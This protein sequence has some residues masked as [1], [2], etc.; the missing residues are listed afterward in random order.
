[1]AP[2]DRPRFEV[3]DVVCAHGDDYRRAHHPSAA[4]EAVLKHIAEC[5]TAALGGHLEQCDSCGHQ[6]ISYNSCRDRHCPKCQNTAR[7]EWITER[8]ERLLPTPYFHVVF[9]IPDQ[10]NPLAL[11]NKNAVFN[12]LF[13]AASQTLL[14]IARDEKHLGAQ[15]G[16]TTVLHTWGQNLFF[17]PHL[18][19][20]VTGGGLSSD[21]P[22]WVSARENYLLPVKVLGKLFRG[23]FLAALDNAYENGKLDLTGSTAELSNPGAWRRF[24]AGLYEKDWVVY[25]K[26]PFGGP[27]HVFQY[28]G[29]Y[30]HR[31]AISNH[32]IV[33]LA[34]GKVTF[35]V[36]DYADGCKK[37]L[38]TLD[39]VE[40]L[41]R[42]LLHVLP[43]G[44][45]RIRHYGLCASANV[46]G[47]LVTARRMLEHGT[48]LAPQP[49]TEPQPAIS[50]P[51][52]ERFCEIT[53]ID[54]MACPACTDGRMTRLRSLFGPTTEFA[55]QSDAKKVDSS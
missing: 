32:R 25:A 7:A 30:T 12:I 2:E 55:E 52:W 37:K 20:V 41:R 39:A 26:P 35:R 42:F 19:C 47:K 51:W 22:R 1:V 33:N 11:R 28:L 27:E 15:V 40:F 29:H 21:G 16:F 10:L 13:T 18:H 49:T 6:R 50:P 14:A 43:K 34:D 44:F 5:R 17:H 3:A 8:L 38:L 45:V 9:T 23:K 54:L 4:Q 24:K 46:N 36:K 53:G 48:D 31:I